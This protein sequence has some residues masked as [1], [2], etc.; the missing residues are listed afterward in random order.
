[1]RIFS[2]ICTDM[3][4]DIVLVQSCL[5]LGYVLSDNN[6]LI[7]LNKSDMCKKLSK[8]RVERVVGVEEHIFS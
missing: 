1:M 6:V 8:A 4:M 7:E 5:R 2:L 3:V